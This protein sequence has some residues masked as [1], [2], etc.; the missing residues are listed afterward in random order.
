MASNLHA[1]H[2]EDPPELPPVVLGVIEGLVS[3]DAGQHLWTGHH[4][5]IVRLLGPSVGLEHLH[6]ML[7]SA[8]GSLVSVLD[9]LFL[10]LVTECHV[11]KH[12]SQL[13][14][15]LL[16]TLD[17]ELCDEAV[18]RVVRDR[19]L[20]QQAP[21]QSA[22]VDV[23]ENVFVLQ[24]G[25]EAN[26]LIHQGLHLIFISA[27]QAFLELEVAVK[28]K[29]LGT[30]RVL[31]QDRLQPLVSALL[32]DSVAVK[33]RRDHVVHFLFQLQHLLSVG[34]R[35][36]NHLLVLHYSG[37][38]ELNVG[39][40][41]R[42]DVWQHGGLFSEDSVHELQ[43][44]VPPVHEHSLGASATHLNQLLRGIQNKLPLH[45]HLEILLRRGV[46]VSAQ[47]SFFVIQAA[48]DLVQELRACVLGHPPS[49]L[50][51]VVLFR[52][53]KQEILEICLVQLATLFLL[54]LP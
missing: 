32:K 53:C 13:L 23:K 54:R 14:D 40:H 47:S 45:D 30:S 26:N 43:L 31:V 6:L 20:V 29:V 18:L 38:P 15:G 10:E 33:A 3:L 4:W 2:V 9:V 28:R 41:N 12:G 52:C 48:L 39:L 42:D 46:K 8:R 16:P 34:R 22:L 51:S 5:S 49:H 19:Q 25:K 35:V 1:A 7:H 50:G 37:T 17:F 24:V 21:R 11:G 44:F 36:V 27:L